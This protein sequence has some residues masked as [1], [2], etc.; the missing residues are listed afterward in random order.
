L[1]DRF[2]VLIQAGAAL[3]GWVA[4]EMFA[5]DPFLVSLL[6][7]TVTHQLEYVLAAGGAVLVLAVGAWLKKRRAR[8]HRR[9]KH[10]LEAAAAHGHGHG[11]GHSHGHSHGHGHGHGHGHKE[12][13]KS[14]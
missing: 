2:P 10:A 11:H 13:S 6:G 3:L 7:E 4:G 1:F 9:E 14:H 12:K 8:A 5:T